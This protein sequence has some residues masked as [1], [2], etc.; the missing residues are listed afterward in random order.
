MA[1]PFQAD[2]GDQVQTEV[3][4]RGL[5]SACPK[6]A[7]PAETGSARFTPG[8]RGSEAWPQV[9]P[10]PATMWRHSPVGRPLGGWVL[11]VYHWHHPQGPHSAVPGQRWAGAQKAPCSAGVPPPSG[12]A[13]PAL[14]LGAQGRGWGGTLVTV[15]GEGGHEL[16]LAGWAWGERTAS[17]LSEGGAPHHPLL[18][19]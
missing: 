1:S 14:A 3:T 4:I 10:S 19:S 7:T 11:R 18:P 16:W 8:N 12:S 15:V 17:A 9:G 13:A 5:R 2:P 6:P